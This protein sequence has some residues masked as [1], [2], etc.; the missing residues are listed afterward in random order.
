MKQPERASTFSCVKVSKLV[1][2]SQLPGFFQELQSYIATKE[3]VRSLGSIH[4]LTYTYAPLVLF[5]RLSPTPMSD[6]H[7]SYTVTIRLGNETMYLTRI[8]NETMYPDKDWE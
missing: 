5:S 6:V 1:V 3:L 4:T 2:V 7:Y 8:G